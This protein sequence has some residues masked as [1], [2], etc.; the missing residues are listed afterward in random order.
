MRDGGHKVGA[1]KTLALVISIV[2]SFNIYGV[3]R[4]PAVRCGRSNKQDVRGP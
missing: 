2:H 1:L 3:S 4:L